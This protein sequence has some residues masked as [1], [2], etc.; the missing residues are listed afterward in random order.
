MTRGP[1][2]PDPEGA[3]LVDIRGLRKT[4][5]NGTAALRGIDLRIDGPGIFGVIG[6]DGAG[7]TT[8]L[9][10]LV[11]IMRFEAEHVAVLGHRLPWGAHALKQEAGYLPQTWGLYRELTIGE[12]LRFFATTRGIPEREFLA[13][14][15]EL[16][17]ITDL[18]PF[19]DRP[20]GVLSG[21]M[22]QKLS[23]ACALLHRPRL[24][25]LDEPNNGVDLMARHE[26]WQLLSRDRG[27]LVVIATSYIDEASRCDELLFL[28]EGRALTRGT[29]GAIVERHG[30]RANAYRVHGRDL[31]DLAEALALEPWV[32]NARFKGSAVEIEAADLPA[33]EVSR[34]L[35]AH[36]AGRGRVALVESHRPDLESALHALTQEALHGEAGHAA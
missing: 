6:P 2:L 11:G 24:L 27:T 31:A 13:R 22:K 20:A 35:L 5:R 33:E 19:E 8:L 32:W 4:F 3:A 17:E 12:N 15:R 28:H 23:I 34:R 26:I 21:G 18:A 14:K 1:A 25:V 29:P 16:L 30:A 10:T 7:K 9:R 36:P